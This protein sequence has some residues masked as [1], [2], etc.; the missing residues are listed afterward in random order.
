MDLEKLKSDQRER[1][2]ANNSQIDKLKKAMELKNKKPLE[3]IAGLE[4]DN[5]ERNSVIAQIESFERIPNIDALM[6]KAVRE[7]PIAGSEKIGLEKPPKPT[8]ERM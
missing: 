2:D 4:K 7:T 3:T 1:I 6:E 5:E 8:T